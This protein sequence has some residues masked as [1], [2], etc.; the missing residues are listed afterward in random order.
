MPAR[1]RKFLRHRVA[2]V[3]FLFLVF[4]STAALFAPQFTRHSYETQSIEEKLETPNARHWMG[5]DSLGRDL[6][7]RILYG[8]RMSLAVGV[9]TA[10][11]SLTVGTVIGAIAGFRGGK[12]DAF[13]MRM[14]DVFY[15]FPSL[16]IAILLTVYLGRGFFGILFALALTS[17]VTQARLVRNLVLQAKEM[18]YV[19]GAR[20][21]GVNS[22]RI[23][24]RHILPNIFAPIIVS[25]TFQI[26][27]NIMSESFLSFIGLGLEPPYSSWGTLANE[28]FRAMKSY[29]H[30]ILFPGTAL[31]VTLLAFNALGDG[32][33]DVLDP[34]GKRDFG[35]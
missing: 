34:Q 5:T 8:A 29:P 23:V 17:W 20:A 3:S 25:L 16:L 28:G 21:M 30:L 35:T 31:F 15:I 14:V 7:S 12:T 1:L 4:V 19:E 6:Y 13:L 11:L 2:L 18:L 26:P 32:I 10:L 27:T 24:V 33:R 9:L 22:T